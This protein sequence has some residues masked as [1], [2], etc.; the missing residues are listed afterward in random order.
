M[1]KIIKSL[2]IITILV[3]A[4]IAPAALTYA[5]KTDADTVSVVFTH[6]MHSHLD[7][8]AKLKTLMDE[9][10]GKHPDSFVL[11]GGD[12]AMGTPYQVT[13]SQQASEL[14]MMDYLGYDATTLGNHEFDYR[15]LGLAGMF[16]AALGL[17]IKVVASNIDWEATLADEELKEDAQVLKDAY[18][19]YGVK[20]YVIIEKG[21]IKAALFGLMGENAVDYAPESGLL[22]KGA[23]ES[24]AETVE[25]I[26]AEED[27]DMIICLS[28]CGTTENENDVMEET[29]DY[30]IAQEVPGIDLI[31]SSHSHTLLH[32]A[33]QVG[34]TYL[35]SCGAYNAYMGHIVLEP[36]NDGSGR[37]SLS[38]Y[39]V[40]PVDNTVADDAAVK[41]ELKKYRALADEEY[42][43]QY[44]FSWEQVIAE[45]SVDFTP[46][47]E[48]GTT[49]GEEPLGNLITDSYKYALGQ[50]GDDADVTV[51]P[52]GVIRGTLDKGEITV[53]DA[54]N[55]SSLGY[56][57]DGQSGY[58]LV[59]A[60][61]TG[62]E[63]KAVAEVDASISGFMGV[64]RLY[65]NGLEYSWN[66]N[67]LIL[68][69]AVDVKINDGENVTSIEDDKLYSVVADLYSCQMLGSVKDQSFGLLKID[70]KDENGQPIT[71]FEDHIIYDGDKELKAW[72]ALASYIDSFEGDQV[73]EDYAEL[74]GRKTEIDSKSPA[75][76]LK[77]PNNIAFIVLAVLLVVII[78]IIA[79]VLL[80]KRIV[81][82]RKNG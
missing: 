67:R 76:L 62:K 34:D 21:G 82:R 29:E 8:M 78:V 52:L 56:G 54:F 43:S 41:E 13:F 15:A 55:R 46:R 45:N 30:L 6:D 80:I 4:G 12:F 2:I 48:V 7:E 61:L 35:V 17:D 50:I 60:Y 5:N 51:V 10:K 58:P 36:K 70:P 75:E 47:R 65:C 9:I 64:A 31:I 73:P 19:A 40:I 79:V 59:K 32:E 49:Q 39:E 20:E 28:H 14:K 38:S 42:F 22:F 72:Y 37:Y 24:A 77:Q 18:D 81:R 11:D 63:L 74:Q 1:K 27:V 57:K 69:R 66:D 44:G 3:I 26:K 68:N 53:A 33:V 25:K 23:A 16:D 71:N